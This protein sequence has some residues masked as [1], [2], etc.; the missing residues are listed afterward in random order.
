M[1]VKSA[2]AVK[3]GAGLLVGE[4][5]GSPVLLRATSNLTDY[6]NKEL[7]KELFAKA[8]LKVGLKRDLRCKTG[9]RR[10]AA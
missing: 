9:Y 6:D 4:L 10:V 2:A 5:C 8:A 7:F 3:N 1:K